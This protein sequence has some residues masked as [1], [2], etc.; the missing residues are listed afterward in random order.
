MKKNKMCVCARAHPPHP[1]ESRERLPGGGAGCA[2]GHTD[3]APGNQAAATP[4]PGTPAATPLVPPSALPPPAPLLVDAEGL[5]V[6][7][8]VS[9]AT[10]FRLDKAD[11]LPDG[12]R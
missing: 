6:L 7:L 9:R 4:R 11:R 12:A 1:P 8:G 5:G 2:C 3:A 10:V